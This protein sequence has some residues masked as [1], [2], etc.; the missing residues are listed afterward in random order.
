[1]HHSATIDHDAVLRARTMLLA[2]G[3]RTPYEEVEAYRVLAR[4]SPAA[5]L[6]RL[7]H[8]LLHLSYDRA[9][10]R[11][12]TER[13]A[14][15]EEAVAAARAVDPA[16]PARADLLHSALEGCQGQLY[17][18]GRR[19]EG[20]A[21]RAERVA[22]GR[23]QAAESGDPVV[24]GLRAWAAGLAEEGRHDEAADALAEWVAAL[25]PK[26][27]VSEGRLTA[28]LLEW[29]A[30]LAA[31]GRAEEAL[32]A[33]AELVALRRRDAA[34]DRT[35]LAQLFHTLVH[36]A[37][38]LHERGRC[39]RAAAV[40]GEAFAVLSELAAT[41]ERRTWS[42]DEGT[43]WA[44]LFSLS[45][46]ANE[47][48]AP[49]ASHPPLGMTP[50]QWSRDTARRHREGR[51]ALGAAA[52]SLTGDAAGRPERHLAE[53]VRLHRCF[54]ARSVVHWEFRRRLLTGETRPLLDEGVDLARRLSGH[55][56]AAGT[57]ALVTALLD[58]AGCR[59]AARLFGPALDDFREALQLLGEAERVS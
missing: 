43:G 58:R 20:L 57:A 23:A 21:L 11:L 1:M 27:P 22:L 46:E 7:V 45:G 28:S 50:E 13:L 34:R 44:T 47:R 2:S 14:L 39:E 12:H 59:T 49:L 15:L 16:E 19:P 52:D 24:R 48:S 6:P 31:A 3:R 40:R 30:V 42:A 25:R 32:D 4:V 55:D 56:P 10:D 41:G 53:L 54:T 51:D 26:D 8:A 17:A 29:T 36:Y 33:F 5:Y 38:M 37:E 35:P 9:Y 18:L